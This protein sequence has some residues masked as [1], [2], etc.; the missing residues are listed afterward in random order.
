MALAADTDRVGYLQYLLAVLTLLYHWA[1]C[2]QGCHRGEHGAYI[3]T[4]TY[5]HVTARGNVCGDSM[6]IPVPCIHLQTVCA[7]RGPNLN[8]MYITVS[9]VRTHIG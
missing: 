5:I 4:G 6:H 1:V 8:Y 2:R 9:S 7:Y 3:H